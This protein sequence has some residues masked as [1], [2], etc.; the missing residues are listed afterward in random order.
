MDHLVMHLLETACLFAARSS[1]H[2]AH[3][4]FSNAQVA[5]P[6]PEPRGFTGSN[7]YKL[8][9][10]FDGTSPTHGMKL[11]LELPCRACRMA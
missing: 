10:T 7:N 1:E 5:L 9:L 6:I 4:S 2:P 11:A 8:Q 3:A